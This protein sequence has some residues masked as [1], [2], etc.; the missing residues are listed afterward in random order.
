MREPAAASAQTR[1]EGSSDFHGHCRGQYSAGGKPIQGRISKRGSRYL[2]TL[3]VQAAD[4]ILMR[5][6]NREKFI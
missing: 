2:R 3:F 5:P 6:H 4:I 1:S